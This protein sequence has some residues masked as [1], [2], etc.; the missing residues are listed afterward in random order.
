MLRRR[1]GL[2]AGTLEGSIGGQPLVARMRYTRTW[3]RDQA[4]WKI[5]AAQ[6][7]FVTD[8]LLDTDD[9]THRG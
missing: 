3:V 9:G 6:A 4:G 8:G 7:T 5:V 2:G 1:E